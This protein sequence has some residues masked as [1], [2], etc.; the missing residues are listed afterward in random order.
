M[1]EEEGKQ[2]LVNR[3]SSSSEISNEKHPPTPQN[4]SV[5]PCQRTFEMNSD[6]IA[7]MLV[8]PPAYKPTKHPFLANN[9]IS[10]GNTTSSSM[11]LDRVLCQR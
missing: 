9:F 2:N 4:E 8:N 3:G 7:A 6:A 11:I 5:Q 1:S 10:N